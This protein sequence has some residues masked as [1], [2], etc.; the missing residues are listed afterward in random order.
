MLERI[1][2]LDKRLHSYITVTGKDELKDA[3]EKM[4][5]LGETIVS[6]QPPGNELEIQTCGLRLPQGRLTKHIKQR[7]HPNKRNMESTWP[8]FLKLACMLLTNNTMR[9]ADFNTI[10]P[11]NFVRHYQK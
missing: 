5:E 7:I 2:A 1:A 4:E 6:F 8:G 3:K 10:S 11:G 9:R